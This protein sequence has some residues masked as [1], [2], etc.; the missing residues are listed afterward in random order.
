WEDLV[1]H[2]ADAGRR[3]LGG[4]AGALHLGGQGAHVLDQAGGE[5]VGRVEAFLGRPGFA[6]GEDGAE[7]GERPDVDRNGEVV[8]RGSHARRFRDTG[9]RGEGRSAP[10]NLALTGLW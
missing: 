6:L 9:A 10:P 5:E 7:V 3:T 8:E 1:L 4:I 2:A